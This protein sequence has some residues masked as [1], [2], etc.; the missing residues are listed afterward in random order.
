MLLL[1]L[2]CVQDG[3][4]S[5]DSPAPSPPRTV[6]SRCSDPSAAPGWTDQAEAWQLVDTLDEDPRRDSGSNTA[7]A[8]L[9]GDGD[10]DVLIGLRSG[11]VSVQENLGRGLGSPQLLG[12]AVA[13]AVGLGD[14]DGDGLLDL[15]VQGEHGAPELWL[16][17]GGLRF[18][19]ASTGLDGS[20]IGNGRGL[21][22][23]DLDGDG[24]LDLYV[25]TSLHDWLLERT[26]SGFE[27]A[28]SRIGLD[29]GWADK[30]W[31]AAWTDL[32][33][34]GAPEL[35]VSNDLQAEYGPSRLYWNRAGELER[36]DGGC[37]CE[38][39][40]YSMGMSVGDVDGNGYQDLLIGSTQSLGL[41]TNQGDGSFVD[42]SA[43]WGL[44]SLLGWDQ[45]SLG[46][47]L[48]DLDL[49]GDLDLFLA[50][51][52]FG[53]GPV[54]ENQTLDQ[55]D[56][57]LWNEAGSF[58]RDERLTDPQDAR[59]VSSGD[60]NGDGWPDLLVGNVEAPSRLWLSDCTDERVS[61]TVELSDGAGNR[62]G[63]GAQ[64][65]LEI[66]EGVQVREVTV[67]RG[68]FGSQHPRAVF[69]LAADEE[70]LALR[71]RWPWTSEAI[72]VDL[73]ELAPVM[74]VER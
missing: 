64:V 41:Y 48:E 54:L 43:A 25:Y 68:L 30:S 51:G 28:S 60:V 67:N 18:E 40:T 34:D 9:D 1:S 6:A 24:D 57:I 32:D 23:G 46:T 61:L 53:E 50:G 63:Q 45:M 3:L 47:L 65:E 59:G 26:S 17:R 21:Q 13:P 12:E 16:N 11:G 29:Q 37:A 8:D 52:R 35:Y 49:D 36:D 5:L 7:L 10:D 58:R 44:N 74:L 62:F 56:L 27:D 38:S 69:G 19:Q 4:D 33:R 31:V 20:M 70:V 14:M 22:P 73:D 55:P 71:V 42:V 39:T 66:A 2:A 15:L 72:E